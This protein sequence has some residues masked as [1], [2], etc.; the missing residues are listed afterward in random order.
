MR[1]YL[2]GADGMLGAALT[3]ALRTSAATAGWT[4]RGVSIGDF[5][6]AD[7]EAVDSSIDDFCPDLVIH[8]AANA[9]V[10]E[11]EADPGLA[12]RVNVNGTRNVATACRRRGGRLVYISSD[13][14]F[15]GRD[16]PAAGYDEADIPNPLSVYGVT[17]LAGEQIAASA[18][19][20]CVIVRTSWLFGGQD[21]R[22][23]NVLAMARK[24]V[25]G[26]PKELISDQF[27]C[28][29]YTPDLARA[30]VYLL[31]LGRPFS[32]TVHVANAGS[33]SWHQVG[34]V[35]REAMAELRSEAD[36]IPAPRPIS[37]ADCKFLGARPRRSALSTRRLSGLGFQM[38]SWRCAVRRFCASIAGGAA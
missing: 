18:D 2:T 32:G 37:L 28:P 3:T 17:K 25:E 34:Q 14:V 1:T 31:T 35:V 19:P 6:I 21:E 15:D 20:G 29:T 10:D 38:P 36:R 27:S 11:C 9:V 30:I 4:I 13:Y 12:L 16:C 22:T 7:A 33:A 24:L 8:T 5:D 26:E 23:D